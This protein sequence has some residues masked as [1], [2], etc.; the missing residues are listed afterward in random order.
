MSKN[1]NLKNIDLNKTQELVKKYSI[2]EI[3]AK[4]IVIK[5]IKENEIEKFIKPTLNDID[6]PFKIKD[7]D[8][9]VER[10]IKAIENKE[11]VCIY[12]D[13]DVD[14]ITSITI[15]YKFLKELEVDVSYYMPNRL[16]DGYGLN[17]E[18][19][20]EILEKSKIDL[21]I[22]V[23]CGITAIEETKYAKELGIDVIIT[24]H[25]KCSE[26]LPDAIAVINPKRVDDTST[27][28][29]HA[30]VGVAYKCL[31]ALS[32][33]LGL[34]AD[35][36]LKYLD[37][38]AL[39]TISDIV[40][41]TG[42]NRVLAKYGLEKMKTTKNIGLASL[43]DLCNMTD[44]DSN[45]VSFSLAPRINACGRMGKADIAVNMFLSNIRSQAIVMAD[46]LDELNKERQNIEREIYEEILN[47]IENS[48]YKNKSSIVLYSPNW[49]NGVLGIV[50]SKLVNMYYKPVVLLTM[51]NG[52][53]RG[54]SRCPNGFSLYN[55]L[56]KCSSLLEQFGGHELAAGLTIKEENIQKFQEEFDNIC[57]KE[58]NKFQIET[59]N[60][61]LELKAKDIT[62]DTIKA[63]NLLKPFGQLNNEPVFIYKNLKINTIST[64]SQDKHLKFT[65]KDDNLNI[66]GIAF[67]AGYRRDEFVVGDKVDVVGNLTLNRFNGAKTIQIIIKDFKKV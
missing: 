64:V 7:M 10:M 48:E 6:D 2:S 40:E 12:G 14:G 17:K 25:H 5:E 53:I 16:T 18:A 9:F 65:L 61:D 67:S 19:I 50:A 26:K 3:L 45:F 11:K 20:N 66:V 34:E 44:L 33:K 1:W 52:V 32:Q 46:R 47:I 22:T 31:I 49:H 24:D 41:L 13:Y 37:I 56:D 60:I 15:M 57:K 29:F 54:S 27:Y 38:V 58:E 42:E 4:L 43:I 21:I 23:D 55:S 63:I 8:K 35:K 36:Y 59:L 39:G 62:I 28:K 30:G 51:E